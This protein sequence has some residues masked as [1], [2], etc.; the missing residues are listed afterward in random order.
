MAF[1]LSE[2]TGLSDK[3]CFYI[4]ERHKNKF[5]YP[6]HSHR[7]YELNFI[8]N[9]AGVRRIIGDSME[10]IGPYE[11]VLVTGENLEH[12]WEQGSCTSEDIREITIQFSPELFDESL[13]AKNQFESIRKMFEAARQGLA[14]PQ[15]AIMKVYSKLDTIARQDDSFNQVLQCIAILH[16]LSQFEGRRLATSAFAKAPRHHESRRVDRIKEYIHTHY[17]DPITLEEIADTISM[18]PSSCSRF[19]RTHAGRTI[20]DYIVDV[21]LGNAA[22]ALVDTN[23]SVS[24]I[25]YRCGFNNLSNFNR[26][27]KARKGTTPSEF[28]KA[29]M[30]KKVVV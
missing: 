21:R 2:I 6:L 27:F 29:Y 9:G 19:F 23:E 25:C 17:A 13:L 14:F 18:S 24:V 26:V 7:D 30:K 15:E 8:S 1:V 10:T 16:E 3:D 12:V 28:R 4:V 11:L 5:T 22:R 20:T